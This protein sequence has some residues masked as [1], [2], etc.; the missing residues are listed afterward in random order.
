MSLRIETL[1]GRLTTRE[2]VG[3]V[4][5]RLLGW[6][7]LR[8]TADGFTVSD[9]A[10]AEIERWGGM[11]SLYAPFRADAWSGRSWSDGI[12]PEERGQAAEALQL[13]IRGA[14]RFGIGTLIAEEA[15]HGHQ[16]LGGT[17]L[18]VNLSI[19]A[20]WDPDALEEASAAV[21]AELAASGAHIALVSALDILRDPRW[22]RSEECFGEDPQLAAELTAAVVRGMQ[23]PDR[24][25]VGEDGVAV[26]LKHLA[27]Q[28]EALGGRNGQSAHLGPHDLAEIH[29]PPVDAGIRA[30]ALGFMAAY[31]DIDG[32]PC[33]ANP[34]LLQDHLRTR[35]GFDGIVMADLGAVDRL[36]DMT[37]DLDSAATA[38]LHAGVDLSL[39]DEAFTGLVA[40]A[41][42]DSA[43]SEALDN[44]CRRVLSLKE[45][46]GLLGADTPGDGS[47]DDTETA[48]TASR[49]RPVVDLVALQ[50]RTA[51]ASRQL[52]TDSLVLLT[53][54]PAHQEE[55]SPILPLDAGTLDRLAVIG[56]FADDVP[57]L[58]GDYVPPLPE[59]S[60]RSILGGLQA[61]L[62]TT[63]VIGVDDVDPE[64]Q[65]LRGC[66][67]VVLVVGGTSH[68]HYDDEFADNGAAAGPSITATGGEGVDL[69]DISLPD[70]QDALIERVR[71]ACGDD[72]PLIAVVVA[73]RPHILTDLVTASAAVLWAGYPGPYGAEAIADVITGRARPTGRLPMTLP[74]HPG[75]VPVRH[76]DRQD[77]GGIYRDAPD[78]VLFPFG[79]GLRYDPVQVAELSADRSGDDVHLAITV[80]N[81]A[82]VPARVVLPVMLRRRGGDRLP[83]R[84]ELLGALR[85][86]VP[87]GAT[88]RLEMTAA[89][90]AVF[91]HPLSRACTTDIHVDGELRTL[92]AI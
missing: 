2:K 36:A 64:G 5:Q 27:A 65:E 73:G 9:E 30:G 87:A 66:D 51:A 72:V 17:L 7:A 32:I 44:A 54:S 41:E 47:A 39:G 10:L 82:E 46:T 78:P 6:K 60:A 42:Q 38:A 67:A 62:P 89:A 92:R 29:L 80:T 49:P 23:G 43:V 91:A 50:D 55:T 12:R 35:H 53:N 14:N 68:R 85:G 31:N 69:A 48:P 76:N 52:A 3:Q 75:V 57:A 24:A 88:V 16:A 19:A 11:G 77:A 61:A 18:P 81:P 59:D 74:R 79:H 84:Q 63:E 33:C 86:D 22:G 28:G 13:A 15:P 56:P 26:V 90:T 71:A 21:A 58:L 83:R 37:G 1:L 40:L 70:G 20:S 34:A 4:N 25:R 45:R 8:R